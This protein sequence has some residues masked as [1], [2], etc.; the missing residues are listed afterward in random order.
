[1]WNLSMWK[2]LR[3]NKGEN[4]AT[5]GDAMTRLAMGLQS[6]ARNTGTTCAGR[7]RSEVQTLTILYTI[8]GRKGT[9]F[10]YRP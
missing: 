2:K 1:M 7:L 5:L 3:E 4:R 10:A 9:P 8:F 6:S